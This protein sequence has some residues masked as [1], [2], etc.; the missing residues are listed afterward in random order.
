MS[1]AEMT[2]EPREGTVDRVYSVRADRRTGLV[3]GCVYLFAVGMHQG[4]VSL[5]RMGLC[6]LL[7]WLI[8]LKE[9][10]IKDI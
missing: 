3:A 9:V 7:R 10:C 6:K 5:S 4:T 8:E 2:S 1:K